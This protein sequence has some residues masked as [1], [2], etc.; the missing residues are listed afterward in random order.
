MSADT[1]DRVP[2]PNTIARMLR[3]SDALREP[4]IRSAIRALRLPPGSRGLD[5][6]CG[7]GSHTHLLAVAVVPDGHVTGCDL[8]SEF[9][10]HARRSAE[11]SD[12]SEGMTFRE[13]D[14]SNLPFEDDTFD[15]AW[16]VDCVGY[17]YA[18]DPLRPIGELARVVRPGGT[19]A[20]LG[21]SSQQ[22][23]PGRP[24]LE[25]ELNATCSCIV[26]LAAGKTPDQHFSNALGWFREVGLVE[27]CAHTLVGD[28]HAPLSELTREALVSLFEMWWNA[29]TSD[30]SEKLR[31]AYERFCRPGSP[32][33]VLDAPDYYAFF[34]YSMFSG[35]VPG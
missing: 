20:I 3:L 17:P 12:L 30:A 21:W 25:A 29:P 4:V 24:L 11:G 15:W 9:L 13:A 31:S 23:L 26:P 34:T 19:V 22:I 33:F 14:V 35:R 18:Q 16:S 6:G 8:A 1:A 10:A 2:D 5:A 7:I 27:C 32:E 28:V